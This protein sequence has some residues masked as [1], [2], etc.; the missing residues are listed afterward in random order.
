MKSTARFITASHE[1][2]LQM[3]AMAP[4]DPIITLPR[5][6]QSL[7]MSS[8]MMPYAAAK[9]PNSTLREETRRGEIAALIPYKAKWVSSPITTPPLTAPGKH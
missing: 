3:A 6:D 9:Q 2:A 7:V 5:S 1:D 4:A 8:H